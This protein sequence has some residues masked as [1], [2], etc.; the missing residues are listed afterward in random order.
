MAKK[1]SQKSLDRWTKQ[2][3]RTKSGKPSTQGPDATGERYL[4]EGAI[5]ALSAEEYNRTT[6]KKRADSKKGKQFSSQPKSTARK[7][8]KYRKK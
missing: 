7:V 2:K 1:K 3:W 4:P 6:A 8:K 5:M